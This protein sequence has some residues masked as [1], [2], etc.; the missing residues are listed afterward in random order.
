MVYVKLRPVLGSS[1]REA[2]IGILI[3]IARIQ[4]FKLRDERENDLVLQR[5][6]VSQEKGKL[7]ELQQQCWAI[8]VP[9]RPAIVKKKESKE[10][11]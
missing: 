11:K 7:K 1:A 8:R 4:R 3:L 10:K 6:A 2:F 5:S 9:H